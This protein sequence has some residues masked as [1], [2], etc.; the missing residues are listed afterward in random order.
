MSILSKLLTKL[1]PEFTD[2]IPNPYYASGSNDVITLDD[3]PDAIINITDHEQV[4]FC[5]TGDLNNTMHQDNQYLEGK[6][7]QKFSKFNSNITSKSE[8]YQSVIRL[9]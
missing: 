8:S 9:I 6:V 2:F 1:K 4:N 7:H 3:S 5:Q